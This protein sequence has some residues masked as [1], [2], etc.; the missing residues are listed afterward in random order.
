MKTRKRSEF[1]SILPDRIASKALLLFKGAEKKSV[2]INIKDTLGNLVSQEIRE[3]LEGEKLLE[4][5][6]GH[7]SPGKYDLSLSAGE[8][9]VSL[10]IYKA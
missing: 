7:I 6:L 3:L 10:P 2:I 4:Y 8:H 9:K 1:V 5:S